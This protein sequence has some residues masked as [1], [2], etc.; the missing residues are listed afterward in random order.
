MF[1]GALKLF[2]LW[3]T[4]DTMIRKIIFALLTGSFPAPEH[5][6][7]LR[8]KIKK[9]GI[10]S[11]FWVLAY[12]RLMTRQNASIPLQTVIR[13]APVFPHGQSGI[14]ISAH[15]E[16]G[17]DCTIFHQVTIGA[18][19]LPA[20]KNYGAPMI[21]N[22]VYIGCGA[23]IIGRVRIGNQVRI[24]ANCIVTRDVPDNC[25]V[26][27]NSPRVIQNS[28]FAENTHRGLDEIR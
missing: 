26:V 3:E 17:Y 5:F 20:S 23:K 21:G 22:N 15:A 1:S 19:T 28:P 16:I 4:D 11:S 7:L 9:G 25:T 6:W 12:V 13:G 10:F 27:M 14:F 2:L 18:N 24:G 8:E